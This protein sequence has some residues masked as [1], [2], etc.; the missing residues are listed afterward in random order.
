MAVWSVIEQVLGLGV[1]P[2][3]L[4]VAQM[5]LRSVVVFVAAIIMVRAGHKRFL[6]K[7]SALDAILGFILASVLARAVNGSAAFF[8]TLAAS[9]LLVI[10]HRVCAALAFRWDRFGV[11]VK[12]DCSQLVQ[13][14]RMM[15]AAMR[16]NSISE[17]DLHEELRLKANTDQLGK[18]EKM[19]IERSGELSVVLKEE[20]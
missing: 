12:G 13:D 2:K 20:A 6:G 9:F 3:D 11:L 19:F 1:E 18:V 16:K 5:C 8:P 17:K 4:S 7:L 14:G 10:L 15:K